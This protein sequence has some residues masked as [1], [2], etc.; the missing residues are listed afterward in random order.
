MPSD[1]QLLDP[2][3]RAER[4]AAAALQ[5]R[6]RRRPGPN[7][8]DCPRSPHQP[9]DQRLAG[10]PTCGKGDDPIEKEQ[11]KD[12]APR[13]ARRTN[14]A[15][16]SRTRS[17]R[18]RGSSR[19]LGNRK[20]WVFGSAPRKTTA[21]PAGSARRNRRR[22]TRGRPFHREGM[23]KELLRPKRRR[24]DCGRSPARGPD[25]RA[26]ACP[27]FRRRI[28]GK[29]RDDPAAPS[30][31]SSSTAILELT[32]IARL[33]T[34]TDAEGKRRPRPGPASRKSRAAATPWRSMPSLFS[35]SAPSPALTKLSWIRQSCRTKKSSRHSNT[36]RSARRHKNLSRSTSG[37]MSTRRSATP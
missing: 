31:S 28:S 37:C 13:P 4:R 24:S 25:D 33:P 19:A 9:R 6:R 23:V 26:T 15:R 14:Y 21:H 29:S 3:L 27:R 10:A 34:Y 17:A 2:G 16:A 35:P 12:A 36:I 8:R 1:F 5:D 18:S 22:P 7:R 30:A 32:P 20:R 11:W